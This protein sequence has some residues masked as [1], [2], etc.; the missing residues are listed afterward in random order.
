MRIRGDVDET[1]SP[2][3]AL[4]ERDGVRPITTE[5]IDPGA[6]YPTPQERRLVGIQPVPRQ[7]M[8][9]LRDQDESAVLG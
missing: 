3:A 7:W 9:N 5:R 8:E 6:E 2:E 1:L 4:Q